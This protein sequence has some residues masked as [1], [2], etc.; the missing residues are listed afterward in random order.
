MTFI[1]E[2]ERVI[3]NTYNVSVTENGAVVFSEKE[4]VKIVFD[5]SVESHYVIVK[6]TVRIDAILYEVAELIELPSLWPPAITDVCSN[7]YDLEGGEEAI[8][9]S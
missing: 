9:N 8:L 3:D 7:V 4:R 5:Y 1:D 6:V 2:L